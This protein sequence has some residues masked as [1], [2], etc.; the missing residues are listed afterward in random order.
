ME[1]IDFEDFEPPLVDARLGGGPVENTVLA[2]HELF[3]TTLWKLPAGETLRWDAGALRIVGVVE[4]E[5]RLRGGVAS[6]GVSLKAG[7]F[8]VIPAAVTDAEFVADSDCTFL[9][10]EPK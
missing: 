2:D 3:R 9:V 7:Q 10:A 8:A 5:M 1:S 6:E 4:G